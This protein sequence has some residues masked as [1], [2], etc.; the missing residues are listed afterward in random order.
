M[1]RQL[2]IELILGSNKAVLTIYECSIFSSSCR[3]G[4]SSDLL[5]TLY[6]GNYP[7][8]IPGNYVLIC[9]SGFSGGDENVK[10]EQTKGTT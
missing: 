9:P 10:C 3:P 1:F 8:D 7:N 5:D 6:N 4:L 2:N